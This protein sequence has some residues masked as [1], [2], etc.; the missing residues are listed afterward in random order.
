MLGVGREYPGLL[1]ERGMRKV[2]ESKD[3][4][5]GWSK[6]SLTEPSNEGY[7]AKK[8]ALPTKMK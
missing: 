6:T 7:G 3:V 5:T 4:K 8:P 2:E 1:L